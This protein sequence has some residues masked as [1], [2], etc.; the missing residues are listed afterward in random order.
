MR[1]DWK[2]LALVIDRM[3]L[4]IYT[5]VCLVGGMGI[6]LNAPVLYDHSLPINSITDGVRDD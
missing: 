5:A 6:M 4:W 1:D 2:F 3:L